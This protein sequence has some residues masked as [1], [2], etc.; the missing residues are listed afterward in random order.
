M[1]KN[2]NFSI[3]NSFYL[4]NLKLNLE[5]N[6]RVPCHAVNPFTGEK[7]PIYLKNESEFGIL[8]SQGVPY[9]DAKLGIPS[10]DN[11]EKDFAIKNELKFVEILQDDKL[12]N[13][14]K[15]KK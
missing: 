8:N 15:V 11:Y 14:E 2:N 6:S 1:S 3:F 12:I 13:S 4:K 9:V 10:L 7:I 5:E